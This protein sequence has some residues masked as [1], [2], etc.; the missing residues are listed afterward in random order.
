M[1][2][3]PIVAD[4]AESG[5][6]RALCLQ[7][8]SNPRLLA[9]LSGELT[10]TVILPNTVT[11]LAAALPKTAAMFRRVR[12]GGQGLILINTDSIGCGY[13]VPGFANGARRSLAGTMA[14][15]LRRFGIHAHA[16]GFCGDQAVGTAGITT[17][18]PNI[19]LGAG[20]TT[21]FASSIGVNFFK[22]NGAGALS[23]SSPEP[24]DLVYVDY[25]TT[26]T[27]GGDLTVDIGGAVLATLASAQAT[28]CRTSG[29]IYLGTPGLH[30]INV[31]RAGGAT[32]QGNV[33]AMRCYNSANP[34]VLLMCIGGNGRS[35]ADL[36]TTGNFGY[37]ASYALLG[38]DLVIG[39]EQ[40]NDWDAD[41]PLATHAA[42]IATMITQG[43]NGGNT[44]FLLLDGPRSTTALATLQ[45]QED[46]HASDAESAKAAG[47]AMVSFWDA[48]GP[49]TGA[50]PIYFDATGHLTDD[51]YGELGYGLAGCIGQALS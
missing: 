24:I 46:Y 29:P 1:P 20:V 17:H 48:L 16:N 51:G 23:Y 13:N 11:S 34:G 45:A 47:V 42:R 38:P 44:D 9:P 7:D 6:I 36:T 4:V 41:V 39:G 19:K 15:A 3:Q 49:N 35:S 21:D 37:P 40:I 50:N 2:R 32:T 28:A 22:I 10:P 25:L 12:G 33:W 5:A 27:A 14:R 26:N 18:N 30:T 43:K 8:G 31:K